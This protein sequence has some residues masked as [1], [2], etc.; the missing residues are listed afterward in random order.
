MRIAI[1]GATG[2]IGS[3]V[4]GE[5]AAREHVVTAVSR[6]GTSPV[7]APAVLP[8]RADGADLHAMVELFVRVDAVVAAI[9]PAAGDEASLPAVTGT[10][11]DAA[12]TARR[13]LVVVG[14]AGP[15]LVPGE[16]GQLVVDAPAY[17][18]PA[19]RAIASA[20]VAQLRVCQAHE[21]A[22]W[23]YI[24]PPARIGP[25]ERTGLYRRGKTTLLI[26]PDGTSSISAEDFAVAVIDELEAP[27]GER[28]FTVASANGSCTS[29]AVD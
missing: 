14:G 5:A 10:L 13:C 20:S 4:V 29:P 17:V 9:R 23:T 22:H 25:A 1:I 16:P 19:Y 24:S 8:V 6:G 11:L 26:D 27:C 18:P 12:A 28:H 3:R 2:M 21:M 7:H 15:L